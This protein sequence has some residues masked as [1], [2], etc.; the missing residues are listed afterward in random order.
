MDFAP[1]HQLGARSY[2][3]QATDS[4]RVIRSQLAR[5]TCLLGFSYNVKICV[6]VNIFSVLFVLFLLVMRIWVDL[7]VLEIW[8]FGSTLKSRQAKPSQAKPSWQHWNG[9]PASL[10]LERGQDGLIC[11]STIDAIAAQ[12]C[13]NK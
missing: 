6:A 12:V 2:E 5:P 13:H 3:V 9:K 1:S 10:L 8:D 4:E 7:Q 11:S